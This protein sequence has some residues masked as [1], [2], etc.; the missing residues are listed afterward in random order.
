MCYC[1][2]PHIW[3]YF[4]LSQEPVLRAPRLP[5]SCHDF[6][7][8]DV[9][10]DVYDGVVMDVDVEVDDFDVDEDEDDDDLPVSW[11]NVI[12][13]IRMEMAWSCRC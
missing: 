7:I 12:I 11:H 10:V 13:V 1:I 4:H 3:L 6:I 2:F 9:E 5:V 8:V